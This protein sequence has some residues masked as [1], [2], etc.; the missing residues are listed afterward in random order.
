MVQWS[1]TICAILVEGIMRNNSVN[2]FRIWASGSG[3]VV[4]KISYLE[5]WPPSCPVEQNNLCTFEREH[6]GEHSC[7]VI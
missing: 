5:L 1:E 6:H 7:Q 2:L 3:D 4:Y